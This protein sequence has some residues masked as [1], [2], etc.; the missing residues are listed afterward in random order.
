MW[1]HKNKRLKVDFYFLPKGWLGQPNFFSIGDNSKILFSSMAYLH[2]GNSQKEFLW[3]LGIPMGPSDPFGSFYMWN[4]L[5]WTNFPWNSMLLVF[6]TLLI[7]QNINK[8][9]INTLT[10][11][12]A[13]QN[14]K[15]GVKKLRKF[16]FLAEK[17][18]LTIKKSR[19]IE[20]IS[21]RGMKL[22]LKWFQG[23][24]LDDPWFLQTFFFQNG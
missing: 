20:T 9:L 10:A 22:G 7:I 2:P 19:K 15:K 3:S 14:R 5:F 23:T 21:L 17:A 24:T 11:D 8:A 1:R 18:G 13:H 16:S 12:L 4:G 6:L